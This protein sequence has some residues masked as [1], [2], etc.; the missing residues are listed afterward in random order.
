MRGKRGFHE[1]GFPSQSAFRRRFLLPAAAVALGLVA[2]FLMAE[3]ILRVFHIQPARYQPPRWLAWDGSV[4]R[5]GDL[6]GGG[7]IKRPSRFEADGNVMGEYVPGARF[8]VGYDSNPRGYFD[9][10]NAVLMTVNSLGLRGEEVSAEKPA[11]TYRILGIGDSFTIGYGVEDEDTFLN[12]LQLQLNAS[13]AAKQRYQ[14]LNAGVGGYNTRDEVM[15][16]E[17]RWLSLNPDLVLI[18][19]YIN[20]AYDDSAILNGGQELGIYDPKPTG[21]ERYSF[22]LDLAAYKYRAYRQ[23]KAV[24][25]YYKQQYFAKA[26]RFLENPGPNKVDWTTC[27]AA[28]ER[29][30]Q[31]TRERNIKLG[32]VIFPELYKLNNGYPFVEIHKLV[33]DTCHRAGIPCLDLFDTFRG[34]DPESLWVHPSD[35]HPNELAH[36]LAAEAIESFVRTEFLKSGG[37]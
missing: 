7:L 3:G 28:L 1:V 14:V 16:L 2:G 22:F 17:H 32:L 20:D 33:G 18:V 27:R 37:I 36:A 11:G 8:K 21:L 19:F 29:A 34:H 4:F 15:Y 6:W 26:G 30:V 10:D 23:S 24:E 35:H 9:R 12:R 25:A 13:P 5:E 31:V